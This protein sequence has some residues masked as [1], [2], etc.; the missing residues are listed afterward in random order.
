MTMKVNIS[1]VLVPALVAALSFASCDDW[2]ETESLNIHTPSIEDQNPELYAQYVKSLNDFKATEH[3]VVIVSVDNVST[4]PA[5]RNQHLTNLPDS[6][7]Y[8]CLNNT[9]KVSEANIAEIG[10]VRKLGTKVLGLVNFDAIESA[11]KAIID[12]EANAVASADEE[13]GEGEGEEPVDNATRFIEYCKSEVAKQIAAS[14]A[15]GVDGIVAN[16]TGI[17]LNILVE[18]SAIAAETSRQGAFFDAVAGWKNANASKSL[19]FKGFPQ[20]VISKDILSNC[21]YIITNGHSA[22]NQYEMSYLILMASIKDVPTDRLVMGVTTPYITNTGTYNGQ[23]SD[24]SSAI[25]SAA[26][27]A[28][29]ITPDYTK[30]GISI[31]G[32]EQDYFNI[33]KIYPNLRE[34]IN[35]LSPTVK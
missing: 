27:W 28:V 9:A 17:D 2:T 14:E 20:N 4:A 5:S 7:D 6:I 22:K 35:T 8:I 24:G 30:A 11:W 23:F 13:T 25:I 19:I 10:E 34:A 29:A 26:Q 15:L 3:Q 1:K 16:F 33:N 21:K 12:E 32:A 18:E 31:D